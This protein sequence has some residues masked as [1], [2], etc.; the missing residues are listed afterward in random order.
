MRRP[1]SNL[2]RAAGVLGL[3]LGAFASLLNLLSSIA[4][5]PPAGM[6]LAPTGDRPGYTPESV[7][8]PAADGRARLRW[9]RVGWPRVPG[10]AALMAW[11]RRRRRLAIVLAVLAV[12]G[13]GVGL[14]AFFTAGATAGS[15]GQSKGGTVGAPTGVTVPAYSNTGTVHVT[16][17]GSTLSN[18][19]AVQ[20]YYVQRYLGSTPSDAC[21]TTLASPTASLSCDDTGVADGQYTY[22][23]SA[24]F[25]NWFKQSTASSTVTVDTVAPVTTASINP[26][27]N[28]AGW[29]RVSPVSVTLTSN[30]GTGSGVAQ[31]KY[32]TDGSDPT[33]S[34]T[35]T[36]YSAPFNVAST[37]TVKFFAKDN[38][39]N[40]ESVKSQ[41][42][43]IDTIAPT[44]SISLS[45]VTG[46]A[47]KSGTTVYYRGVNAGSFTLTN[48]VADTGGSGPASSATAA[49][50]GTSTLWTHA[51]STVTTPAGGPYVST[52]FSWSAGASS[53]PT[54][55][56]TGA[57]VAD[58][59]TAA[60][61]LTF[62]NDSTGPSGG[63]VDATGLVGTGSRYSTSTTLSIAF[64]NGTDS[65]SGLA[66]AGAQLLRASALLSSS[67]GT[68][69]GTCG[70][71]GSF[72]QVGVNDPSSPQSDT[73]T[74][75]RCYQY[76]Y[77][78][79]DNVGN[80]TT[81]T[82][83]DIKVDTTAPTSPTTATITP[84]TGTGFQFVS[85]STVFYNPTQAGSFNVD[86]S[87][88]DGDSGIKQLAFPVLGGFTATP[89][90]GIVT[91]PNSGTTFRATY[92][93]SNNGASASPGSQQLTATNN[94]SLTTIKGNAFVVTKDAT[95]PS[96]GSVD[97]TGLVGT[98]SR[99]STSTTL[100][101]ALAK[102]SDA[103]SGLAATGAVLK[104]AEAT[105]SSG[106]TAN[107]TCAA[108]GAPA[109]LATDPTT[110]Y[111]DNA[112][113]GITTGHC[114]QYQYVVLDNVGNST[115]YTSGDVK[116]DTSAPSAPTPTLS[117][118]SGNAFISGTTV[119]TNPQAGKSG[120][121]TVTSSPTDIQSGILNTIFPALTGFTSG[122][123][124]VTSSPYTTTYAWSG[125]GATA[126]GSKTITATNNANLTNTDTF[127]VTPDTANPTGGSITANGGNTFNP[128]GTVSLSK[129]DFT[130]AGSGIA[131]NVITRATATLT[132]NTCVS[133]SGST[134]VTIAGGN[135]STTLTTACYQ[136]TLTGTDKVGNA[137]TALSTIVKVDTAAPTISAS[138]IAKTA[139]GTPG[140]I[141]QGGTY[142]VYAN[143]TDAASGVNTVTAD[144]S[145]ITTGATAVTLTAGSFTIG[146]VTYSHRSASQ[147]A[148]GSLSGSPSYSITAADNASNSVT[149][150]TFSVTVDN[151]GP[152]A[153]DIQA[154]NGGGTAGKV[155]SGDVVTYTFS[156]PMDPNSILAGWDGTSTSVT[157]SL[158]N[159]GTNDTLTVSGVNLGTI[160][161]GGDY[162]MST[163]TVTAN[164]VLSGSTVTLTLT[165]SPQNGQLNTI[166]TSTMV[167][168]PSA[169][170]T[171]RAGNAMSTTAR[172]ET[173]APKQNF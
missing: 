167:W 95:S 144:V 145:T 146:G 54:E 147:T 123:G 155:G 15:G 32:T 159:V 13:L 66:A 142:F 8:E 68:S 49:L 18:G 30:D 63:S 11:A 53:S 162:M 51:P 47:F 5:D 64:S 124:T 150:S 113:G 42:V 118:A 117:A 149:N 37:S 170:A 3:I 173:G 29:N 121:F 7:P 84:V 114:Y 40:S 67:D 105:L 57:D 12:F 69:D 168:T 166:A 74:D 81:Y 33:T 172:T 14:Y 96:G 156:E 82:S 131:S 27:P 134:V 119:Y 165:A 19:G 140:F 164:M 39:G 16:W 154:T 106:G 109:T 28:A 10:L 80:S 31:I 75:H 163:Q 88:S 98:G 89:V 79:F 87:T 151:I 25:H 141:K 46:G 125:A 56:V 153:I 55:V 21:G 132:N 101:I 102:G 115:T 71:Y 152:T 73:V 136:Y 157:V 24:V 22:K 97:A 60:P 171:D 110:P 36:V 122:G 26:V 91:T 135:D 78:V 161:L 116:V 52:L 83:P 143:V 100:S 6:D 70:S 160:A 120:G 104:R 90:S 130:D 111:A 112:A 4:G 139:G 1:L 76:E 158:N 127:T 137:V 103:G 38:A 92:S 128:T 169:S 72:V 107:G 17:T 44:N 85:G 48:A 65:G 94:A 77:V 59:T 9:P 34:G 148:N 133:F 35:A 2:S 43:K 99:Y 129:V 23:V 62:T 58:N 86:S 93:W 41:A 45:N 126:S 138:M 50:G 20:G 61:A 108:Y